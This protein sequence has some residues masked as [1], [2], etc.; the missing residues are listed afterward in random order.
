MYSMVV[1]LGV[2]IF[3]ANAFGFGLPGGL[4]DGLDPKKMAEDTVKAKAAEAKGKAAAKAKSAVDGV[5]GKASAAATA[6]I[7]T[8]GNAFP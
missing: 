7:P 8:V 1:A 6:K 4:G 2:V 3:S 5:K